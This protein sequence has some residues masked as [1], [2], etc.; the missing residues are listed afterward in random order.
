MQPVRYR[1][2]SQEAMMNI[3]R[4]DTICPLSKYREDENEN[5]S[6]RKIEIRE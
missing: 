1:A 6:D 5:E 2:I 3:H 4:E